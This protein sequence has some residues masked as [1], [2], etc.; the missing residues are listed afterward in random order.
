MIHCQNGRLNWMEF[1]RSLSWLLS[2]IICKVGERDAHF[3]IARH[4]NP[5]IFE[6]VP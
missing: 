5:F 1:H 4:V 6:S 3:S 2:L